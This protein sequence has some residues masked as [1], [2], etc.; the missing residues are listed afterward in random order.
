MSSDFEMDLRW[1]KAT[2]AL[3]LW[4]VTPHLVHAQNRSAYDYVDPLIGTI[5]G[6][7]TS[8][9]KRLGWN[10]NPG[11]DMRYRPCVSGRDVAFRY[12]DQRSYTS[13]LVHPFDIY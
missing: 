13:S 9:S 8:S 1:K 5:N 3:T 11:I 4:A 6:G 12:A 10:F 2:V 7:K